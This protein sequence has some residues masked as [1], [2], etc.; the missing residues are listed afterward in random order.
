[1]EDT[2]KMKD[3]VIDDSDEDGIYSDN[4]KKNEKMVEFTNGS[5]HYDNSDCKEE[6][7]MIGFDS[8]HKEMDNQSNPLTKLEVSSY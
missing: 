1:M 5:S 3:N 6:N 7:K 2:Q 4:N 8:K